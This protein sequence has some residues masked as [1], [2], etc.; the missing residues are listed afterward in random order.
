MIQKFLPHSPTKSTI[1]YGIF[2][3]K[4][5]TDEEFHL[6][7]DMYERVM[8][9]DKVL[10]NNA[11]ANLNRGVFNNGLLHPRYEK[12]PLFFQQKVREAVTA[13]GK[14]E[15]TEGR[16]IWPASYEEVTKNEEQVDRNDVTDISRGTQK[17]LLA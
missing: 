2:K 7:A 8:R 13:H 11:Q 12:A 1:V 9:E 3:N 5:S 6:I 15:K 14:R 16:E 4:N 17:V 10:C